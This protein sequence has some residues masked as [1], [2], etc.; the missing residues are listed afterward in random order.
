MK[1]FFV[2]VPVNDNSCAAI[3]ELTDMQL[4][5]HAHKQHLPASLIG[6]SEF[7]KSRYFVPYVYSEQVSYKP[8]QLI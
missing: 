5:T 6:Y 8:Y 3:F 7:D 2:S 4:V 1:L